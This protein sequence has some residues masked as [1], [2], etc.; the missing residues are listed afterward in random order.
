MKLV[1]EGTSDAAILAAISHHAFDSDV[2]V[3]ATSAGGPP[4]YNSVPFHVKM[5]GLGNLYKLVDDHGAILGGAVLFPDDDR[6][7][8]GRIFVAPAHFRKGC[9]TFIMEEIEAMFPDAKELVL[10]TPIWN[11]R[12]NA[13]YAKLG[14]GEMRRDQEFVYYSKKIG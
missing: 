7:Q 3:G 12:T 8:V 11:A 6:L 14:Y 9:G 4:G 5:A 2:E 10:D 1:K 13:F